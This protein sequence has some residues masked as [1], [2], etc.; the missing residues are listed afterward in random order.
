MGRYRSTHINTLY[1]FPG[2]WSVKGNTTQ[3]IHSYPYY[4]IQCRTDTAY[5]HLYIYICIYIHISI[6]N[7]H[8]LAQARVSSGKHPYISMPI[9]RL[10]AGAIFAR[11]RHR[12]QLS[13]V[14]SAHI[15]ACLQWYIN[16]SRIYTSVTNGDPWE[17]HI[18]T[19]VA[20]MLLHPYIG[21][22]PGS[23]PLVQTGFSP[24]L[25]RAKAQ[26]YYSMRF[27]VLVSAISSG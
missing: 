18:I 7:F 4:N 26:C 17:F 14:R 20:S 10:C 27:I 19:H 12:C 25:G 13:T 11:R 3:T 2:I 8:A 16:G 6:E 21:I 24:I 1:P 9:I 15:S 23:L 22:I 5:I